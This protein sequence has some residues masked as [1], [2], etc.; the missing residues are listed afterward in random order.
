MLA[1][2][3]RVFGLAARSRVLPPQGRPLGIG[4]SFRVVG[5]LRYRPYWLSD[6]TLP[7]AISPAVWS[8]RKRLGWLLFS[9][10]HVPSLEFRLPLEFH[11]AK[12]SQP[13]AADQL[14]SWAFAPYSTSKDRRSTCRGLTRPLRSTFRVWLPSWRFPP[15]DPAPVLFHTGSAR[16]IHPSELSPPE[17][18]P[19]YYHPDE[20]TYRFAYR[21]SRRGKRWAGPNR[22]RFLGFHPFESP[23]QAGKGLVRRPLDAPM[24]FSLAGS[25]IGSLA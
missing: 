3:F 25:A 23:W 4:C 22:L 11:P 6:P 5:L 10:Q 21:C 16:G 9:F 15:L 12:P 1:A 17:R 7:L 19:G 8:S 2:P 18:Y 20:P 24:G 14:L 13:A